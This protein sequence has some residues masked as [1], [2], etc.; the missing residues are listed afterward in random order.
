MMVRHILLIASL[1]LSA[2][3]AKSQQTINT[4]ASNVSF[5]ISNMGFNTVEGTFSDMKGTVRFDGNDLPHSLLDVCVSAESVNTESESRDEHL[6]KEDFFHVEVYPTI[7]FRSTT[8]TRNT[9]GYVANGTLTMHGVS[10]D[11]SIPFTFSNNTFEG[12]FSLDRTDYGVGSDG[13]FMVGK[14][15][16][17]T[18]VCVLN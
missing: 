8:V 15:V 7:C 10:K 1:I 14:T 9:S 11:V 17:L 3:V 2:H 12:S 4:K 13:G 6:R 5:E 18:I 16:E